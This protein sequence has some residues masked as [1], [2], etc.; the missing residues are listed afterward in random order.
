MD[1]IYRFV[2]QLT[3]VTTV[4]FDVRANHDTGVSR[5]GLSLLAA[6]A[7][8]VGKEGWRLVVVARPWQD[9]EARRA[10]ASLDVPVLTCPD[11]HGFVRDSPWL[12]GQLRKRQADLYYTTHYT[13]DRK[14]P[15]PFVYT[16]HDLTRL[17][18]PRLSY[19]DADFAERFGHDELEA[20]RREIAALAGHDVLAAGPVFLRYFRALNLYLARRAER[21]VTISCS[22]ATDIKRLLGVSDVR[23]DLVPGGVDGSVFRPRGDPEVHAVMARHGVRGPYLLYVGLVHPSKR[24]EWLL[25]RL[26]EA[27]AALP[28]GSRL[29]VAGGHAEKS[30]LVRDI[31]TRGQAEDFVVFAGRVADDE[32]AALYTGASAYVTA[33]VSEGFGL[34]LLEAR[35]CGTQVIGTDIPALRETLAD[36]AHFYR[37]SDAAHLTALAAAALGG[38]LARIPSQPLPFAWETS[39]SLLVRALARA[40][41]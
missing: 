26:V 21:I 27:R 35:A 4:V 3:T 5:Y 14:C 8:Y 30:P 31:V 11:D 36:S 13:V 40:M 16:I 9:D 12:R 28:P 10:V 19:S 18:Y 41:T 33:A 34:P 7:P 37:P 23:L 32:L 6:A 39:G 20:A 29:V 24:F 22:T 1:H 38:Q 17:R 2:V 25:E 15:V